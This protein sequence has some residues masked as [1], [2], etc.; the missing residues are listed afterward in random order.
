MHGNNAAHGGHHGSHH[1]GHGGFIIWF[2]IVRAFPVIIPL[3]IL[4]LLF[5]V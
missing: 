1:G 4:A 5:G 2:M 3:G